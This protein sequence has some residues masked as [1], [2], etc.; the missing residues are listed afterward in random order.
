MFKS[1]Q[2]K[3]TTTATSTTKK[4]NNKFVFQQCQITREIN[5]AQISTNDTH[6]R[7]IAGD[8]LCNSKYKYAILE[9][10]ECENIPCTCSLR[11][12]EKAWTG[13]LH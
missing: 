11:Q 8:T 10:K 13:Q 7:S 9:T 4:I 12:S 5:V 1:L 3:Q 2:I 6:N